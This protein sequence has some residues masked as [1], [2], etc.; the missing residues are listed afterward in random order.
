MFR[1]NAARLAAPAAV[2]TRSKL[3]TL[4]KILLGEVQFKNKAAVKESHIEQ[5]FG[6]SWKK[7]LTEYAAK[8]GAEEKKILERQV[9]RLN[10]TRYTTREL[11]NFGGNGPSNIDA[12]AR[13]AMVC[14]AIGFLNTQGEQAFVE[15]V[16]K[17]AR[18]ANWSESQ[19]QQFIQEVKSSKGKK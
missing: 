6:A 9:A 4:H 3:Q 18:I 1:V 19:T 17:E 16:N 2:E 7:D 8:L 12:A 14:Q 11:A 5:Q 10:A 15:H 13:G